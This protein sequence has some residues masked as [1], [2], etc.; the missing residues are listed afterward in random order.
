ME[1]IDIWIDPELGCGGKGLIFYG[2]L[3]TSDLL[4]YAFNLIFVNMGIISNECESTMEKGECY[5][6]YNKVLFV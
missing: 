2:F 3:V 6:F 1:I 4:L 5:L